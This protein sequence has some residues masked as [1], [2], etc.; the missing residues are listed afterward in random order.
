MK[1]GITGAQ[2]IPAIEAIYVVLPWQQS[3][4]ARWE[5]DR[6]SIGHLNGAHGHCCAVWMTR[7]TSIV[8]S[9]I[10]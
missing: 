6:L 2:T 1:R 9:T 7:S 10:W 8:S 5:G 4:V 3:P